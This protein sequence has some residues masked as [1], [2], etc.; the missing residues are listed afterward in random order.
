MCMQDKIWDA[1]NRQAKKKEKKKNS[2]LFLLGSITLIISDLET[3]MTFPIKALHCISLSC[4]L[5]FTL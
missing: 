1:V 5:S 3:Y 4:P 2:A